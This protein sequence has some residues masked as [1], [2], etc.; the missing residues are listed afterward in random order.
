MIKGKKDAAKKAGEMPTKTQLHKV[1]LARKRS[2]YSKD[3]T[4]CETKQKRSRKYQEEL[5][6]KLNDDPVKKEECKRKRSEY[7]APIRAYEK[8]AT[9][10]NKRY[11][12]MSGKAP[13][14]M[15]QKETTLSFGKVSRNYLFVFPQMKTLSQ[16]IY[17]ECEPLGKM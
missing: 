12:S 16:D 15:S 9:N 3:C 8:W 2:K 14:K 7:M 17:Y 5:R 6:K 11:E 10:H 13:S 4:H 1:V